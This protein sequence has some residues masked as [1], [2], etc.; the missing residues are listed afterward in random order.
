MA[1][2]RAALPSGTGA[3]LHVDLRFDL[4]VDLRFEPRGT[5]LR[6]GLTDALRDAG[7]TQSGQR[8]PPHWHLGHL[9]ASPGARSAPSDSISLFC[10]TRTP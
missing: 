4:N 5:G 9:S 3:D 6:S 10:T 2:E 7:G 1:K 8:V